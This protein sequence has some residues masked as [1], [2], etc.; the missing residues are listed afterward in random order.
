MMKMYALGE[1]KV[2]NFINKN[3]FTF[4]LI[5]IDMDTVIGTTIKRI[6]LMKRVTSYWV[7]HGA[8]DIGGRRCTYYVRGS[9]GFFSS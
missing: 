3:T 4:E 8:N 2:T 6:F 9:V 1:L 7:S 5:N